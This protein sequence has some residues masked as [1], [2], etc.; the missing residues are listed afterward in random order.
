MKNTLRVFIIALAIYLNI[1][2][3]F[4]QKTFREDFP[5]R[6]VVQKHDTLWDISNKFLNIPWY[7]PEIW[8]L[9]PQIENPH[10]IFPGDVIS[11]VYVDGKP[12]LTVNRT[13]KMSPSTGT[14]KLL[15]RMRPLAITNAIPSIP[16]EQINSWL[17]NNR[18]MEEA[19]FIDSPYVVAGQE[20]RLIL[21]S[22][23]RLFARGDFALNIPV[24]GIYRIGSEYIDPD[25]DE[26]LGVQ[27]IDI[28]SA[29]MRALDSDIAT[30]SVTR[31]TSDIRIGDRILPT[32]VRLIEPTFFPSESENTINGK[33]INVERGVFQVGLLDVVAV[34]VGE[35]DE[36]E[37]GN[38]LAIYRLGEVITDRLAETRKD[39]IITLPDQRAGMMMI[40][41]TFEKMSLALVLE[42]DRG[43]KVG[44]NVRNP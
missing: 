11:L 26:V 27:V 21:G 15:P 1:P 44:D 36:I 6:Y 10:L 19:N 24:Y 31:A 32:E 30:L 23:D 29:S 17:L 3:A 8:H 33:I 16:L 39:Q 14:V 20:K 25:T 18:I 35:R 40:F 5:E 9:N 37:P 28:G 42:A 22:G 13:H 41:Q 12:R 38:M 4:A 7:W 34:N 43:I 2:A